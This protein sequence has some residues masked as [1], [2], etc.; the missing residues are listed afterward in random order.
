MRPAAVLFRIAATI[1]LGIVPSG[2]AKSQTTPSTSKSAQAPIPTVPATKM[3]AFKPA[4]GS[5]L[6]T[7]L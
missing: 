3:E 5:V 2:C 1:T 4:A 6:T 7:R